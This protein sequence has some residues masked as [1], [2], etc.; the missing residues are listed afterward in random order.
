M[1][2]SI[3]AISLTHRQRHHPF[4]PVWEEETH[5]IHGK[6]ASL[7]DHPHTGLRQVAERLRQQD[8]IRMCFNHRFA[9]RYQCQLVKHNRLLQEL[10]GVIGLQIV[11]QK[12]HTAVGQR[13]RGVF[14][15]GI[16]CRQHY[17]NRPLQRGYF[18]PQNTSQRG[19]TPPPPPHAE[20][21]ER[22]RHRQA[23]SRHSTARA[24]VANVPVSQVISQ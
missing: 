22:E 1:G 20:R 19:A 2:V 10:T 15:G 14:L 18:R 13:R 5:L 6:V 21:R 4:F 17:P 7:E 12:A 8:G 16:E 23:E 11:L 9:T 3:P 24:P